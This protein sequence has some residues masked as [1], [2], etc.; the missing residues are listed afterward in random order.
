MQRRREHISK[1]DSEPNTRKNNADAR[2]PAG[3]PVASIILPF[4]T[5][6]FAPTQKTARKGSEYPR[7]GRSRYQMSKAVWTTFSANASARSGNVWYSACD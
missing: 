7:S 4:A 5:G 2:S 1:K 3:D 6:R